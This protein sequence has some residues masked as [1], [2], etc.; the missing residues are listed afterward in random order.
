M[1]ECCSADGCAPTLREKTRAPEPL[2]SARSR[3][4]GKK[5]GLPHSVTQLCLVKWRMNVWLRDHPGSTWGSVGILG[6]GLVELLSSVGRI[7]TYDDLKSLVAERWGWWT[8][9]GEELSKV[10]CPLNIPFEAV[11]AK[12]RPQLKR[13]AS[14][15]E[16]TLRPGRNYPT[17]APSNHFQSRVASKGPPRGAAAVPTPTNSALTRRPG[18]SPRLL[19][20]LI[21]H[22]NLSYGAQPLFQP[23]FAKP[24]H[25]GARLYTRLQTSLVD[26]SHLRLRVGFMPRPGSPPNPPANRLFP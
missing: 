5:K 22:R 2:P 24:Q 6:D 14:T 23:R 1:G 25:L 18:H 9:Y 20:Y 4:K 17:Q 15:I 10:V 19:R 8:T 21:P 7:P 12:S 11:P 3:T 16:P 26:H 13:K